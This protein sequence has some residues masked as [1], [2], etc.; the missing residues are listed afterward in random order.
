MPTRDGFIDV[1]RSSDGG[2]TEI[3]AHWLEHKILGKGFRRTPLQKKADA[4]Q[5]AAE[6][7]KK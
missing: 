7:A 6:P 3:P 4:E 5:S 2:K 1:Y